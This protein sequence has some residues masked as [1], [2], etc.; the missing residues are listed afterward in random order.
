MKI[1]CDINSENLFRDF[2]ETKID[3]TG[4]VP[5]PVTTPRCDHLRLL[6]EG[7]G[8]VTIYSLMRKIESG[9]DM[10]V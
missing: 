7:K 5:F 10:Y 1:S 8:K 4:S 2:G 6:I 3:K 9:S